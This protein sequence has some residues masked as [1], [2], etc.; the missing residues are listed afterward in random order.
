MKGGYGGG[1]EDDRRRTWARRLVM[2]EDGAEGHAFAVE[3]GPKEKEGTLSLR[4]KER[5]Q[6]LNL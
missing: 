6:E 3:N 2:S 1:S 5:G 4:R